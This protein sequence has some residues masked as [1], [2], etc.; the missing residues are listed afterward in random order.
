MSKFKNQFARVDTLLSS[1]VTDSGT[2]TVGYPTGFTRE[3]FNKGQALTA[4]SYMIVND[5]DRWTQAGTKMEVTTFGA[6]TITITNSTGATLAAG[7]RVSIY[8]DVADGNEVLVLTVPVNLASVT[9][10]QD[11]LTTLYPGVAGTIEYFAFVVNIPVTTGS[12]L[13]SFNLEIGTTNVTG[14]VIALTSANATPMGAV[15]ESSAIT[16]ANT[17]AV[18]SA[19]SIEAASVTAFS[20]GSGEFVIRIRRSISDEY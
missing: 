16:A 3:S 7:S 17:L 9:T 4:N 2:F 20:E 14:G 12:K 10:T 19:L 1:A 6:S 13:A 11:I 15:V 8:I 18:N 5:N